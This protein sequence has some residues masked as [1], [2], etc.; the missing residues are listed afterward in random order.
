MNR[1]GSVSRL[2]TVVQTIAVTG[3][4]CGIGWLLFR[5]LGADSLRGDEA[6][7]AEVVLDSRAS[8]SWLPTVLRGEAW[9]NKPP[10]GLLTMAASF[11][12]LGVSEEAA[13]APAAV[14]GL[15][16]VLLVFV[17]GAARLGAVAGAL[18]ATIVATAPVALGWH[19]F[20]AATFDAATA[21]LVT[22][23]VLAHLES[24]EPGRERLFRLTV[25]LSALSTLLKSLAGPA[26]IATAGVAIELCRGLRERRPREATRRA[27]I[28]AGA[29]LAAGIAVLGFLIAAASLGG[30]DDA[31]GRMVG[32]DLLRRNL[33]RV[34]PSH[35]GPWWF[36]LDRLVLDFGPLLALLLP[37]AWSFRSGGAQAA[38]PLAAPRLAPV[39]LLAAA[40][41]IVVIL[42]LSA[43][44]LRW[45]AL[46]V[47]PLAALAIAAGFV[48][49]A[50]GRS[51]LV[52]F[53]LA[54]ALTVVVAERA[55]FALRRTATP[56]RRTH[57]DRALEETRRI[58]GA[59]L[60][61][62][63]GLDPFAAVGRGAYAWDEASSNSFYLRLAREALAATEAPAAGC[64]V[65]LVARSAATAEPGAPR[66]ELPPDEG[67]FALVDGC[68]GR[69]VAALGGPG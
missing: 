60:V 1:S 49:L 10:G 39:E 56:P 35:A 61:S 53:A 54:A 13:R 50:R 66:L 51:R 47:L 31:V 23:A 30:L 29:V 11:R 46:Q 45:Y 27:A 59:R 62:A 14:G 19:A 63:A 25:A 8:G 18:A 21:L 64:T 6:L 3:I 15:L 67:P 4:A 9:V 55:S 69:I 44:K 32:W 68:D 16:C 5:N 52:K 38:P 2:R 48:V 7:Y 12:V 57:L 41:A 24:L 37:A 20:R 28:R 58:P 40:A 26:L 43:S 17:W 36:Y 42:S 34:H 33:A 22:A 65:T